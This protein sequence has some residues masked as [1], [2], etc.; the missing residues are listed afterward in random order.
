MN[1]TEDFWNKRIE[2]TLA[3]AN[4]RHDGKIQIKPKSSNAWFWWVLTVLIKI[5]TFGTGPNL[6]KNFTTTLGRT[7]YL[8]G[9]GNA[10]Y[11][12]PAQTRYETI[13]HELSH[14]DYMYFGEPDL[15]GHPGRA[16]VRGSYLH[17]LA[18]ALLYLFWPVPY[19]YAYG[20]QEIEW[21][22]FLQNVRLATYC[23]GGRCPAHVMAWVVRHFSGPTYAW[24]ATM[25][26][27]QEI[28]QEL[29]NQAEMEYRTGCLEVLLFG[30]ELT[31]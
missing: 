10:F 2:R 9:D 1:L 25:G 18:H 27:A 19:R 4:A 31:E 11:G 6:V 14:F 15:H 22:G 30:E 26:R 29:K 13:R 21:W 7:M 16:R 8:A 3:L 23:C 17:M 20:R 5:V 24:M 28:A 12:L